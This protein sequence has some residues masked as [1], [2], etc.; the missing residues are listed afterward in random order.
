MDSS[1]LETA[2]LFS[3]YLINELQKAP[4]GS[5]GLPWSS[6]VIVND[7]LICQ[8][9]TPKDYNGL[10]W[11]PMGSIGLHW[12]SIVIV[13]SQ[14]HSHLSTMDSKGLQWTTMGYNGLQ[15]APMGSTGLQ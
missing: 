5:I 9:W 1:E 11:A 8:Q 14:W 4:I 2:Q 15:W 12:S 13:N 7:L 10:Q 6:I 3:N